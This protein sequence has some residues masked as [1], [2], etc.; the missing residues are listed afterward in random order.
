[1]QVSK[2]VRKDLHVWRRRQY[3]SGCAATVT[4]V[5][6]LTP[7]NRGQRFDWLANRLGAIQCV[8]SLKTGN[9]HNEHN[10]GIMKCI[11]GVSLV[12]ITGIAH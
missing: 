4:P 9:S 2:S 8:E 5:V 1:M 3:Q 11:D 6:T 10:N 7:L 12:W